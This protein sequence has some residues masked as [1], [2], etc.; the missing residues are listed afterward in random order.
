M[1]I[2]VLLLPHGGHSSN[3]TAHFPHIDRMEMPAKFEMCAPQLSCYIKYLNMRGHFFSSVLLS[4]ELNVTVAHCAAFSISPHPTPSMNE[5]EKCVRRIQKSTQCAC[6]YAK[7]KW[8]LFFFATFC[9]FFGNKY[10]GL[11]R[12]CNNNCCWF[13]IYILRMYNNWKHCLF[14]LFQNGFFH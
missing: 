4:G 13:Y 3:L 2:I 9:F 1:S 12:S 11:D 6:A 7:V 14:F 10:S 8:K 5:A